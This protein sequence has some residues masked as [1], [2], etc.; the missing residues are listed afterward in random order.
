M[1]VRLH[2]RL[3]DLFSNTR[4]YTLKF[5]IVDVGTLS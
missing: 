1:L 5:L 3:E 2:N 4:D